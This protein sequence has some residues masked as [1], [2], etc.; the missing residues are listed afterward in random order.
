VQALLV[1]F[2]FSLAPHHSSSDVF[3][4]QKYLS[5]IIP[6]ILVGLRN[7][8]AKDLCMTSVGVVVDI[9]GAVGVHIQP[10]CDAI[11]SVLV[12]C[13]KDGSVHRDIK[14]VMLSSFGDMALA[15]GAGFEPYLQVASLLLMQASQ[16]PIQ[17]GDDDLVDFINRLRVSV[18]D[19]YMGIIGGLA[20]GNV[21]HLFV[22]YIP[23]VLQFIQ[24]LSTPESY[25]D[26]L[27]LQK[28]VALIGDIAQQMGSNAEIRQ[29]LNQPFVGQLIQEAGRSTVDATRDVAMWAHGV[30]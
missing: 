10:F 15:I 13:L 8:E 11:A 16:A 26:D 25:K 1:S 20:E 27:C 17:L 29:Q 30:L 4:F 14:P 7:F 21:L 5:G 9:C 2:R 22:R 12:E 23:L 24:V 6:F 28:A 18:L 3:F 19:S